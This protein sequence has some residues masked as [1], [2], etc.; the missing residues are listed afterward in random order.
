MWGRET[1]KHEEPEDTHA[2]LSLIEGRVNL[3]DGIRTDGLTTA[4]REELLPLRRENM[5]LHEERPIS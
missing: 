3:V 4:E 5:H 2:H 1:I